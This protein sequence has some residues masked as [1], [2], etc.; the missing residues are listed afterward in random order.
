MPDHVH[1]F[2][3]LPIAEV[4]LERWIRMLRTVLGKEL[5]R[6]GA[7][8]RIGR[9]DFSITFCGAARVTHRS[10][11]TCGLIQF[12]PVSARIRRS[13][14]IRVK[15]WRFAS[16]NNEPFYSAVRPFCSHGSV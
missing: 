7:Q 16:T 4:T 5:L 14:L 13:G 8:S 9:R 12:V 10:G 15:W 6:L 11:N 3:H 2:V 1:L